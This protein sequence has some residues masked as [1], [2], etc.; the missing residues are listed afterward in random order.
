MI[1]KSFEEVEK[2]I[3]YFENVRTYAVTKKIYN[4]KQGFI[5]GIIEFW[6]DCRLEFSEVKDIEVEQ[7][8][9]YRYHYM[10]KDDQLIFRYDNAAHHEEIQTFP[11]HKH[12]KTEVIDSL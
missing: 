12:L 5:R 9:K 4:D 2:V 1:E 6:D 11:H 8:I 7:K 10:D 3:T